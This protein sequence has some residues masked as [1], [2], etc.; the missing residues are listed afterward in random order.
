MRKYRHC[1]IYKFDIAEDCKARQ[2]LE[3]V[4]ELG[5]CQLVKGRTHKAGHT[6]DLILARIGS[7]FVTGVSVSSLITDHH[8]LV[9]SVGLDRP[10][11][12]KKTISYRDFKAINIDVLEEDL[13]KLPLIMTPAFI[14]E[15]QDATLDALV[16]QYEEVRTVIESHAK[17]KTKQ[18]TVRD[19]SPWITSA[20]LDGRRKLRKAERIWRGGGYLEG[21]FE[22]FKQ[23]SSQYS[24]ILQQAKSNYLCSIVSECSGDQKKTLQS[25]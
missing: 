13:L 8:L 19:S 23:A 20:V 24:A 7:L 4:G 14:P 1:I 21:H 10:V 11:R 3:L 22:S 2:F 9:C 16:I 12:V 25:S 15:D 5:W 17:V 6:L 18:V